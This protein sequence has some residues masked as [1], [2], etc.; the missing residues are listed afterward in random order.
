MANVVADGTY[1]NY[2]GANLNEIFFEPTFRSDDILGNYR[3]IPNVKHDINVFSSA[4]LT[5]IVESYSD[6][7]AGLTGGSSNLDSKTLTAGRCRVGLEQCA[8]EF[9][10]TYIEE[11]YRSGVD[12]MNVEGTVVGEVMTRRTV[13]GIGQDVVRLSWGGDTAA[14]TPSGYNV[15]EGWFK[16]MAGL[17]SIEEGSATVGAVTATQ[18]LSLIRAVYDG[19]PAALQQVA[20]NEKKMFVTPRLYNAYLAN[21]E[22][23]SSDLAWAAQKDGVMKVSFRG[24]ELVPMYE[25]DTTL[26]DYAA[27]SNY[28]AI[29]EDSAATPVECNDGVCYCATENLIVGTDVS[30]PQGQMKMWYDDKDEKTYVRAYF[31][32][33]VQ[34]LFDSLV[35][36][37]IVTST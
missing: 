9:M 1:A 13:E 34:Y 25:W 3:V 11:L 29:F 26:T 14:G 4:N 32:L 36:W 15:F 12:A 33:G 10:N 19:A 17:T 27:S 31:K 8:D 24:V 18:A 21:L 37:G 2:T 28:P 5:K 22:G 6:C 7:T 30:D 20:A 16:K 23:T 35:Q